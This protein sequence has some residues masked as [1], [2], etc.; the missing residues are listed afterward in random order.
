[1]EAVILLNG[2][3]DKVV[4]KQVIDRTG[5]H[6]NVGRI[7]AV[8]LFGGSEQYVID[9]GDGG[10]ERYRFDQLEILKSL[11]DKLGE[12]HYDAEDFALRIR[13]SQLVND[14][15]RTGSLYRMRIDLL[16]HQLRIADKAISTTAAGFLIADDVGLGKTIEAGLVMKYMIAHGRADRILLICPA[17]LIYQWREQLDERFDDY[18]DI[19]REEMNVHDPKKWDLVPRVI[20]SIDS[21]KLEEH[22]N[23]LISASRDWDLVVVDEA[24]HLSARHYGT[25]TERTYNYRL[26]EALRKKTRFFLF[27]TATPHQGEDD[28]FALLLKLLDATYVNTVG[29]LDRLGDKINDLVGRNLK[30]DVTDFNKQPIFKGHVIIPHRVK[31][32]NQYSG[33]LSQ[34]NDYVKN[35]FGSMEGKNKRDQLATGFV[36]TSL[37]KLASSSPDALRLSLEKRH[38]RLTGE[39]R[40]REATR[41]PD[42]R[43]EGESEEEAVA[44]RGEIFSGELD[45][46]KALIDALK[47]MP[48]PKIEML[49]TII[50]SEGY[51]TDSEKRLLIFT[52][53]CGTQTAVG[54][55]LK[56]LFGADSVVEI[57]GDMDVHRKREAI[58]AFEKTSRFLV[59]T[60]AGGE[61]IDLQKRCFTMVNYDLP[62]N[63]MRLHQRTGRLDR[64]GQ[65]HKVIS[66]YIVVEGTIDDKIQDFLSDK[67]RRIEK[68]MKELQGDKGQ[69]LREDIL[70]RVSLSRDDLSRMHVSEDQTS[71]LRVE[72]DIDDAME[73]MKRQEAVL[74]RITGFNMAEVRKLEAEYSLG[75]LQDLIRGYL[76]GRHKRLVKEDDGVVHFEVP[77]EILEMG[78]FHGRKLIFG[79]IR[80]TFERRSKDGPTVKLLGVGDEY[81]DAILDKII[82]RTDVGDV[83]ASR[84]ET[85]SHSLL[86]LKEVLFGSYSVTSVS[87]KDAHPSFDGIE[88]VAYVPGVDRLIDDQESLRP[89]LEGIVDTGRHQTANH[90][91]LPE[92]DRLSRI[93]D[94]MTV[95]VNSR[96]REGRVGSATL[97]AL[98]W[99]QFVEPGELKKSP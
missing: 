88:F 72:K 5:R 7:L 44:S 89:I 91:E 50:E 62:W 54:Q 93:L 84:I 74:E 43:F 23:R 83:I 40:E 73:A 39:T 18:F 70:G 75:D 11:A 67:I 64:Y 13:A 77:D 14:N 10:I 71:K 59:S 60:E 25:K 46:I 92:K 96:S 82:H 69:T 41:D 24:H 12:D 97:N 87:M 16:P 36:L 33:L 85:N 80:G 21:L 29:D 49:D 81:I 15:L 45:R 22:M 9:F 78:S 34:V 76:E 51:K 3:T 32:S 42:E 19:F 6:P 56:S 35:G 53:Y 55:H 47:N 1:M 98:A 20:A 26:L 27:L 63:P 58:A 99:L 31:P 65:Q 48:D 61:G 37:L 90:S 28:R 4:G 66:H 68:R 52:E 57:N 95:F 79:Q 94:E 38:H 86:E 17:G 30:K 8:E 2:Q